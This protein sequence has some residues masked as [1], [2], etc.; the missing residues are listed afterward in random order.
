MK[1]F[2]N[3]NRKLLATRKRARIKK[4]KKRKGKVKGKVI[5]KY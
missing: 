1:K 4:N 5:V 2:K 3:K